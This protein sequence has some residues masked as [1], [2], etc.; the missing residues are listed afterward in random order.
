MSAAAT[1][2]LDRR[3]LARKSL[4]R[5]TRRFEPAGHRAVDAAGMMATIGFIEHAP[6]R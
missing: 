4:D 2:F 1:A 5:R 3:T 6:L